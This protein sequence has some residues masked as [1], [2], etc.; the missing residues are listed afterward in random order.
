MNRSKKRRAATIGVVVACATVAWHSASAQSADDFKAAARSKGCESIPYEM[1][2]V[3]CKQHQAAADEL[4]KG[5]P[6]TC[7]GLGTKAIRAEIAAVT[8]KIESLKDERDGMRNQMTGADGEKKDNLDAKTADLE[9]VAAENTE[10][11]AA[12]EKTLDADLAEIDPRLD[13]GKKCRDERN[14]VREVFAAAAQT[15]HQETDA[16]KKP[17]AD[18]LIEGWNKDRDERAKA[19]K[20]VNEGIE[21]CEKS[22]AG[23]L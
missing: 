17:L 10:S 11:L 23:D 8:A 14:A 6:W 16:V 13:K 22:R 3:A 15:A 20:R 12:L 5:E 21:Q 7:E 19:Q 4:C 1:L 18:A 9:A 2:I